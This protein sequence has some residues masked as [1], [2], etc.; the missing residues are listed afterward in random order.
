MKQHLWDW[1]NLKKIKFWIF[2]TFGCHMVPLNCKDAE[3][4][5][6]CRNFR[7]KLKF[8]SRFL[9]GNRQ[10]SADMWPEGPVSP[11]FLPKMFLLKT[12]KN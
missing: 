1:Q 10:T 9:A 5:E 11:K 8:K 2:V 3:N 7:K 12:D 6:K 4:D